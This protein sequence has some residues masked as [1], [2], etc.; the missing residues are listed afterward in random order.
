MENAFKLEDITF[1][2]LIKD[3]IDTLFT[4]IVFVSAN[5]WKKGLIFREGVLCSIQSNKTGELLG[6]TLVEIGLITEEQNELSL[7][8]A[9][10]ERKKQG[11]VLLEMGLIQPK[12]INEALKRQIA[13][14]FSDIFSWE[15][16]IVQ[17]VAK[18]RIGK[19]SDVTRNEFFRLVRRGIMEFAP[20]ST[21]VAALTPYAATKPKKLTDDFPP[22]LAVTMDNIDQFKVSELLLLGQDPP[23]ALLSLY[24]TGLVSFEESKHKAVIDN[25]R[26]ILNRIKDQDPF[27]V[28]GVDKTISDGGLKR[29]YIKLVKANHPDTY[30]HA[31][32]PEVKRLANEI[33]TEIQKAYTTVSRIRE[34][35]PSEEKKGIDETLQ[36]EILFSQGMEALKKK[37][38]GKA[39]DSF[40]V[41]VK[42]NPEEKIF[43]EWYVKAMYLR[44]Q[45][46]G[47]GN[48]HEIKVAIREGTQKFPG[49]DVLYLVLGWVLK[50]EGSSKA[51]D[52][53]R[54]ALQINR[55]NAEAQREMRLYT[56]RTGK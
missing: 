6:N 55:N 31:D 44:L 42:L 48:A 46:T 13:T 28:L 18:D 50:R 11:V 54:K 53:F 43:L 9:R 51:P 41:C 21:I 30:A 17:K 14:R 16:G 20:F 26:Q 40:R 2:L 36:A 25:L 12:E 34:G 32:D 38:Y 22:D 5:D 39:L 7:K 33:F 8:K 29:A 37:D 47:K 52:A 1:P 56:L 35:M 49:S 45:N 19:A 24:C 3:I 23:R 27:E 4:G 10:L 15:S